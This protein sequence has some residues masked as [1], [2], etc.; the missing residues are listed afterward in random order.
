MEASQ[1]RRHSLVEVVEV[2]EVEGVAELQP[3]EQVEDEVEQ[4]GMRKRQLKTGPLERL[5]TVKTENKKVGKRRNMP[6]INSVPV[7]KTTLKLKNVGSVRF[8]F[9]KEVLYAHRGCIYL[10][11]NTVK[12]LIL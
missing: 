1:V 4:G 7:S 5:R 11:K 8:M 9:L 2:V 10:L 12:T 3:Q 6:H